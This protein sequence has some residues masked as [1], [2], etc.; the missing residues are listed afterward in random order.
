M[1]SFKIAALPVSN[2]SEISRNESKMFAYPVVAK[3]STN[4]SD[5]VK[6]MFSRIFGTGKALQTFAA[7]LAWKL[8]AP[9]I[10]KGRDGAE[11]FRPAGQL[12]TSSVIF[13]K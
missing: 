1:V 8:V 5:R 13:T 9:G 2:R 7:L 10:G 12:Q 3:V 6:T 4:F 11:N